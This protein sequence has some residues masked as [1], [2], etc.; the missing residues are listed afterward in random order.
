MSILPA[1]RAA[2]IE[3]LLNTHVS[4]Q[5]TGQFRFSVSRSIDYLVPYAGQ[6]FSCADTAIYGFLINQ[7]WRSRATQPFP[8]SHASLGGRSDDAI[9]GKLSRRTGRNLTLASLGL[10]AQLTWF[11]HPVSDTVKRRADVPFPLRAHKDRDD[12]QRVLCE[13]LFEGGSS[14][15]HNLQQLERSLQAMFLS[16]NF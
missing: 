11:G 8:R 16:P 15:V 12:G 6:P 1:G 14:T 5:I 4:G 9:P 7:T 2:C 3:V 13:R 10:M